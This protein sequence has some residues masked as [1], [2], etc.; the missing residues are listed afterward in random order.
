VAARKTLS[1]SA[2]STGLARP[3]FQNYMDVLWG[4]ERSSLCSVYISHHLEL[5]WV[6]ID[7]FF[8]CG[9][10]KVDLVLFSAREPFLGD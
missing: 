8:S 1:H 3:R 7:P 4:K 6:S 2:L 10:G 9:C 5:K